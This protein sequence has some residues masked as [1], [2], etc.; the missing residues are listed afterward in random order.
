MA[1]T[2]SGPSSTRSGLIGRTRHAL[3]RRV[4]PV[5]FP[6]LPGT[7]Q[8]WGPPR[9]YCA[10]VHEW[11]ARDGGTFGARFDTVYPPESFSWREA[12]TIESR[13]PLVL[14]G[15]PTADA[16][17]H[18]VAVFPGG[19]VLGREAAI[20][21]PDDQVLLDLSLYFAPYHHEVF[22]RWRQPPCRDA[23]GPVLVLAGLPGHNYGHWIHQMLPRLHLAQQ[24]GWKN[25]DWAAIIVNESRNGFAR[26]SAEL[27]GL[28]PEKILVA[29]DTL[30]LSGRP[31]VVPTIPYAGNYP[32]WVVDFLRETYWRGP[33]PPRTRRLY[34]SRQR[35]AWRHIANE[36]A[37]VPV[38]R[39]FGF[40]TIFTE[41]LS[42]LEAVEVCRA[43]EAV[44]GLHGANLANMCFCQPGAT[45]VQ[46][47]HPGHPETYYRNF[48]SHC[49]LE[50]YYLLGEGPRRD[51]PLHPSDPLNHSDV[52]VDPEKLR[53][54]FLAAGLRPRAP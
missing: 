17:R 3:L 54:T 31:L 39:D 34:L 22:R 30:H 50:Y 40:E 33:T 12:R 42:F 6:N 18:G 32:R 36:A 4:A 5:L 26:E 48:A 8:H 27:A 2:S 41:S 47:Y 19:R 20:V 49:D 13:P 51:Q 1:T 24:A 10:T 44:C 14:Q 15:S 43:A 11:F 29:D 23:A 28:P 45:L 21:T 7:S 9:R 25:S 53:Q 35:A 52:V 16:E 37:L 46:I 38:L